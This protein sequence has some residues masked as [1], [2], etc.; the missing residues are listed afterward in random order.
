MV[1]FHTRST[2]GPTVNSSEVRFFF[3]T[4]QYFCYL[5]ELNVHFFQCVLFQVFVHD[6]ITEQTLVSRSSE[7]EAAIQS[8]ERSSLKA[9]CE[10]KSQHSEYV[11]YSFR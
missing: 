3:F 2:G 4:L 7:F 10:K 8:G 1:S 5:E 11:T 6:I 9:L